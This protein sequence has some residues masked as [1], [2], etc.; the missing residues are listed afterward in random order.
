MSTVTLTKWGNSIGI[1]IPSVL[2]KQAHLAPGEELEIIANKQGGFTLV[3][4][5]NQQKGWLDMF[6]AIADSDANDN[7]PLSNISNDFDED[8]W[9]W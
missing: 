3:P 8:E 4:I 1:R 5:K 7:T 2:I 6:N 9:T